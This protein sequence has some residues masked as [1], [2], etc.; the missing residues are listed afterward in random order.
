MD[1]GVDYFKQI[2][3]EILYEDIKPP[4]I[5]K[6]RGTV[7]TYTGYELKSSDKMDSSENAIIKNEKV[8]NVEGLNRTLV[9]KSSVPMNG[10]ENFN[11][12][13]NIHKNE[14]EVLY[15]SME[16]RGRTKTFFK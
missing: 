11:V 16:Q 4:L 8:V 2:K 3:K 13:V 12:L 9:S 15:F 10:N 5:N 14:T 1:D 6:E 7:I